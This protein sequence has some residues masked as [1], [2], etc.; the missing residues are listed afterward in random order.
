MTLFGP[1]RKA[2]LDYWA[3]Q[4]GRTILDAHGNYLL[5]DT[6][7]G[8]YECDWQNKYA[9]GHVNLFCSLGDWGCNLTDLLKDDRF[10]AL[11]LD[12]QDHSIV[13]FRH[14]TKILLV[15]SELLTDFQDMYLHTVGLPH[16][17]ANNQT[18]RSFYFPIDD[19]ITSILNFINRTCK[20]KTQHIHACNDHIPIIF[21][22]SSKA[23]PRSHNYVSLDDSLTAGKNA[24]LVPKLRH[25]LG[26]VV[27]CY[28]RLNSYF[29]SHKAQFT[30]LCVNFS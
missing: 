6:F 3:E 27:A 9:P 23:R 18:A 8:A 21:E 28:R 30:A 24:V 10:D 26:S 13:V 11:D 2:T 16:N 12:N 17:R 15:I 19:R 4:T 14:F 22:D 1:I 5:T 7:E 25:L 20:H 29:S